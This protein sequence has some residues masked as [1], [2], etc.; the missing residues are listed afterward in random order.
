MMMRI[1][2]FMKTIL[3]EKE[4]KHSLN[5]EPSNPDESL[6]ITSTIPEEETEKLLN[7]D[8][9]NPEIMIEIMKTISENEGKKYLL[10]EDPSNPYETIAIDAKIEDGKL[11]ITDFESDHDPDG[12]R[13]WKVITFDQENTRKVL[14]Y[15][16]KKNREAPF[17]ELAKMIGYTKRTQVFLDQC[18]K[19][20]INYTKQLC[21]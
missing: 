9:N 12:G 1:F 3:G 21:F 17:G 20:G 15:L 19:R 2:R 4:T 7:E 6:G 13:S 14:G 5:G 18:E 11:V 8:S 16:M 10:Y